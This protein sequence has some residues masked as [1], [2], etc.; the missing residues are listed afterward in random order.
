ML[1][2]AAYGAVYGHVEGGRFRSRMR[3]GEGRYRFC[4]EKMGVG[5][6]RA[7]VGFRGPVQCVCNRLER[8][9]GAKRLHALG[10]VQQELPEGTV[11]S[12]GVC[13]RSGDDKRKEN[14]DVSCNRRCS[15]HIQGILNAE[16]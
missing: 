10:E 1:I 16:A 8:G 2:V 6:H 11:E 14:D 9:G 7:V 15:A 5:R 12:G 3:G 13:M 4:L